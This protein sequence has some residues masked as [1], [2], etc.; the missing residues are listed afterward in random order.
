MTAFSIR[1]RIELSATSNRRKLAKRQVRFQYP[2]SD[3]IVC[4]PLLAKR[5]DRGENVLSVSAIGSNCLQPPIEH[6][7]KFKNDLLFQYPQSDRIVCNPPRPNPLF[8]ASLYN[9]SPT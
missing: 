5:I 7:R 4:N 8:Y 3:R 6:L 1:N 9:F 2:Q